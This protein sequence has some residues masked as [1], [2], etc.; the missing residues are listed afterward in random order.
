MFAFLCVLAGLLAVFAVVSVATW[1]WY[2]PLIVRVFGE[3][4]WLQPRQFPAVPGAEE[5]RFTTSDG[6][7][8]RGSYLPT[9]APSRR[10]VILFGHELGGNRWGA[11]GYAGELRDR[12]FDVFTFDFRNHGQSD[13][14]LGY[15]PM[16]WLTEY[17][18]ADLQAALDYLC[19]RPDADPA[20]VGLFGVSRGGNAALC[21]AAA[22]ERV[23]AVV[24]DGAFPIDAMLRHYIRRFMGIYVRIPLV[25]DYLPDFC[26][27]SYYQWAKLLLGLR[28]RCRFVNVEQACRRVWQPVFMIHGE[29][30]RYIPTGMAETLRHALSGRSKLWVVPGVKHNGAV[31]EVQQEYHRRIWRFFQRHLAAQAP[32]PLRSTRRRGRPRRHRRPASRCRACPDYLPTRNGW[33]KQ[34]APL[35]RD[36]LPVPPM[37]GIARRKHNVTGAA[38]TATGHR[39]AGTSGCHRALGKRDPSRDWR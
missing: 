19:S 9:T 36:S 29:R 23:R 24:T 6:L 38:V 10:G 1:I 8:L 26:L 31:A 32:A 25:A 17:E 2:V 35:A 5:C 22:D 34:T 33:E 16:P 11:T 20:G 30:D 7:V 21:V 18:V 28:R 4:P 27:I 13:S 14:L 12:G 37:V 15:Q 3:T 39:I